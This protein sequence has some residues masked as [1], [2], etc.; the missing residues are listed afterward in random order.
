LKG[1]LRDVHFAVD[2]RKRFHVALSLRDGRLFNWNE[3]R[4]LALV[5]R[6][7]SGYF[8]RVCSPARTYFGYY[9]KGRGYRFRE[10]NLGEGPRFKGILP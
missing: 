2:R 10:V 3:V 7:Q 5:A 1:D 4:G 6:G 9:L 8:P